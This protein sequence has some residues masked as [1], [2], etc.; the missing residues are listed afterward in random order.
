MMSVM[1]DPRPIDTD[2]IA[3]PDGIDELIERLAEH[4]HDIWARTRMAEGWSYGPERNDGKKQHPDLVPYGDLPEGE[5]EYDRKTAI[6]LVKAIV[7]LGYRVAK[8][9][10]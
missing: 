4:N 6:G 7:A 8:A 3:L 5:K 9:P 2:H 1:Y 10:R